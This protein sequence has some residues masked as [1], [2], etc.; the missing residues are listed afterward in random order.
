MS[1]MTRLFFAKQY[2][3]YKYLYKTLYSEI[4]KKCLKR[5][6]ALTFGFAL[7][8]SFLSPVKH[9]KAGDILMGAASISERFFRG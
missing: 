8:S 2:H 7:I 4:G 6:K 1:R 3:Y 5:L 9:K